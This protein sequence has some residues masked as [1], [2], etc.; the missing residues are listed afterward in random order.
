MLLEIESLSSDII[1]DFAILQRALV[2]NKTNLASAYA[3]LEIDQ[4][5]LKLVDEVYKRTNT[6]M[7]I[8]QDILKLVSLKC[9]IFCY[10]MW[11]HVTFATW[12]NIYR[13]LVLCSQGC[14][15]TIIMIMVD[16]SQTIGP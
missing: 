15:R 9:L 16:G 8:D 14:S 1:D 10:K 2:E 6:D 7:E 4:D 11:M 5:I 12:M 3:H 13:L